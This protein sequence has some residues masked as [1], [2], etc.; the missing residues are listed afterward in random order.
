MVGSTH[1]F[2]ASCTLMKNKKKI[3]KKAESFVLTFISI[4]DPTSKPTVFANSTHDS[5]PEQSTSH[6]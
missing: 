6:V 3:E 2:A 1:I 5:N 4:H